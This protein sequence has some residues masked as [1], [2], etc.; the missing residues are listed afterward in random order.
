MINDYKYINI[1]WKRV[2]EH[3][4]IALSIPNPENK[5]FVNHI[6]GLKYDN[7]V[8][9]LEWCTHK[10][11]MYHSLYV[12]WNIKLLKWSS[13]SKKINQY[14]LDWTFIKT[15]DSIK[16]ASDELWLK[17]NALWYCVTH[18]KIKMLGGFIWE[19]YNDKK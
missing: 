4:Y 3:R 12:L 6:N 5:P 7:R 17:Q 11:N 18:K 2:A 8:E 10:E 14:T 15:W 16:N 9:N 1:D 19:I 13:N